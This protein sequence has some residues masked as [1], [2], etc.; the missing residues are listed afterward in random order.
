MGAG[1]DQKGWPP[2]P[3][4]K[5]QDPTDPGAG[6]AA[7]ATPAARRRFGGVVHDERGNATLLWAAADGPNEGRRVPLAIVDETANRERRRPRDL[8][9][10]GEWIKLRRAVAARRDGGED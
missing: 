1:R 6:D 3:A 10:L 5:L 2:Q 7:D 9:K 8:R 4:G